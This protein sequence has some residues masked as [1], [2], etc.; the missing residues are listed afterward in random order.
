[1]ILTA[2]NNYRIK[3][4][5]VAYRVWCTILLSVFSISGY[6][7]GQK[8]IQSFPNT[9]L[10]TA[11]A[12]S[13]DTFGKDWTFFA[14]DD[15]LVQYDNSVFRIFN[16]NNRYSTRSVSFDRENNRIYV[17]GISEFGYFFPSSKNSLEYVCLSD[18]LGKDRHVGNIWGIYPSKETV[19]VQGDVSVIIYDEKTKKYSLIDTACKLDCSE[20]IDDVLWL[21]TDDGLKILMGKTIVDAHGAEIL[22]G[23]RIRS[24]L[25]FGNAILIV[26]SD[27]GVYRYDRNV[28]TRLD[29]ASNAAMSLGEV[30]SADLKGNLLALGSID[31]GVGVV[32]LTSGSTKLYNEATGLPNN[33]VLSMHF[34]ESGDLWAGLEVGV[35]KILLTFPVETFTNNS[36]PI[37]SGYV[38]AIIDG[39]MYLGT[40]RGLFYVDY[41]PGSDLSRTTFRQVEGLRGQV[42]GLRVIGDDLFCSHDR[43]LYVV[44]GEKAVKVD[45]VKASWNV[46]RFRNN[47]DKAYV[48]TYFGFQVIRKHKGNWQ[49]DGNVSGY[50]GSCYNFTQESPTK[51]WTNDGEE[52]L[53]R[54][55]ID[56]VEMKVDKI[57]NFR[58][59]ED[60]LP[61]KGG[62]SISRIDNDIYFSTISGIYR[63]DSK[64]ESIIKDEGVSVLLGSPQNVSRVKKTGGWIYALTDKELL[65]ADP[66]GIL[67]MRRIPLPQ[68]DAK[69][70][71]D[72]DVMFPIA[73]DYVA[74]PTRNGYAFFDFSDTSPEDSVAYKKPL[75]R[76]N[77]VAVTAMK[78]SAIFQDNFLGIKDKIVLKNSENSI[79][80]EFGSPMELA[81][82]VVYFSRFK[83]DKWSAPMSSGIKEF[84][85]LKEGDYIFE[86]RAL[87]A[88]GSESIDSIEFTVLPPWWRSLWAMIFYFVLFALIVWCCV[89][90]G[91]R[92]VRRKQLDLVKEKDAEIA[93]QQADFEWESKL[94]DHKI[95]QLE[96]EQLDK[97]LRHKAQE[98]ATVMMS[99][100][101]KNETLQTVK[102]E[103]QNIQQLLPKTSTDARR[104]LQELQGK[105]TVDIKSDEVLKRV[106]EEFDLVHN[107]FIKK[108][109]MDYPDLTNNEV[110]MCAYIK[111]NLSTK[112]IAPLLNISVRGVKT[113]RYRIRKKFNLER[114]DSLTEFL[115]K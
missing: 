104:A 100:A 41:F 26:T 1:M 50:T 113:M 48:G 83:G 58:E 112:E 81:Q 54:L 74:Y 30:F 99:L 9:P 92:R 86:V 52:G 10:A 97:E 15:G 75:A 103:L 43:G 22:K 24:I 45:G 67:G 2:D 56:T 72:G 78:D 28:L 60:G 11:K 3:I 64:T 77:R 108:L 6:P 25:P 91:K 38:L 27:R 36:L 44:N 21:G 4:K 33:T 102:R 7:L 79:K 106:E 107:D 115:S 34:D 88:D 105:V 5:S 39:K 61:L 93:R 87:A 71:H 63:Y 82:G 111:M 66:A 59:T 32:D 37:G 84:T 16:I 18:S 65:Q 51:V 90:L 57:Y 73:P 69:P 110:L 8:M 49:L 95:V 98:M 20:M 96:K 13:I 109:R 85:N 80:I 94:K 55:V 23:T 76:I 29:A 70:M 114:E 14:T 31:N 12:W 62:V 40:N 19:V 17:G 101:H 35:A 47:P 89:L 46:E 53:C 68:S 42:W